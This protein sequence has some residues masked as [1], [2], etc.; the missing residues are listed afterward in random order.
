MPQNLGY[1]RQ[2]CA[3][4]GQIGSSG[5]AEVMEAEIGNLRYFQCSNKR[6]PQLHRLLSFARTREDE[7]GVQSPDL[8]AFA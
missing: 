5:M 6:I 4:H 7:I 1:L 3:A 2:G 8:A